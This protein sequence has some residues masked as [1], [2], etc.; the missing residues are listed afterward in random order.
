MAKGTMNGMNIHPIL[1]NFDTRTTSDTSIGEIR[2]VRDT[3]IMNGTRRVIVHPS[4]KKM[5]SLS[6]K[7]QINKAYHDAAGRVSAAWMPAMA[8]EDRYE[9]IMNAMNIRLTR[10]PDESQAALSVIVEAR[11]FIRYA[12]N[13]LRGEPACYLES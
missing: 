2:A 11:D 4:T 12:K 3:R 7:V 9:E 8:D 10:A 13:G 6:G 1:P 5:G